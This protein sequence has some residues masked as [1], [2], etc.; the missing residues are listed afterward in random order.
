MSTSSRLESARPLAPYRQDQ[1]LQ[2]ILERKS[3]TV[4]DLARQFGVATATIRRDLRELEAQGLVQRAHG[5]A[6]ALVSSVVPDPPLDQRV[7]LRAAEKERLGAAAA[8]L[9]GDGET[10]ILDAGTTTLAIA[11]HLVGRR[12][13]TVATISLSILSLLAKNPSITTISVGGVVSARADAL[14]GHIA[15]RTLRDIHADKV[16]LSAGGVSLEHGISIPVVQ[17]VAVKQA[18]IASG[19]EVILVADASKLGKRSVY[20]VSGVGAIQRLITD[21][22]APGDF[23]DEVRSR[24]IDVILA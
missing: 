11:R 8:A 23:V 7:V 2:I 10:V 16:F 20:T 3:V 14:V 6:L 17:L 9:V 13:I 1:I 21:H 5:G 18:M 22:E 4:A 15:E 19:K 12:G 24:G